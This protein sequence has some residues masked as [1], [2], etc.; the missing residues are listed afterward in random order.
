MAVL[1]TET[2][3]VEYHYIPGPRFFKSTINA[4]LNNWIQH[5]KNTAATCIF[6]QI[7]AAADNLALAKEEA[8]R[9]LE[10]SGLPFYLAISPKKAAVSAE[11]KAAMANVQSA[12]NLYTAV[13]A[14]S[15][16]VVLDPR[17]N[18]SALSSRI[19]KHL[20]P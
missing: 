16:A 6:A 8:T 19:I 3:K 2:G 14:W 5:C 13:Q 11:S 9:S 18:R 1:D 17:V 7:E 20:T 15:D 4:P 10:A 12:D